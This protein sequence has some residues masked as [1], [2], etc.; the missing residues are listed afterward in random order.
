MIVIELRAPLRA[1][2][3]GKGME[4]LLL[5]QF[6]L[7][8][9]VPSSTTIDQD[10]PS[11]SNSQ[12]ILESQSL[13]IANDVEEDNHDLD[14]AHMN[15]NPFFEVK[16]SNDGHNI[17]LSRTTYFTKSQRHFLNQSKYAL[18]SL[19]KYGMESSDPVDIP[20]VEKS[21]LDAR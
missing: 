4:N 21:K 1:L 12:I 8:Q 6:P 13:V 16:M 17:I 7:H 11:P 15:N 10:A 20:M 5:I 9:P 18:K 19:K 2:K 3:Y 14:V